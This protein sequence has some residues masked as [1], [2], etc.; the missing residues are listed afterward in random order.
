MDAEPF[1]PRMVDEAPASHERSF[2]MRKRSW[3]MALCLALVAGVMTALPATAQTEPGA[4]GGVVPAT[5][6]IADPDGDANGY[7]ALNPGSPG[8]VSFTGADILAVW[9]TNDETNLYVHI[10]TTSGARAESQ[11]F[12]T[13][14]GPA[15]KANCLQ[16]RM[17]TEGEAVEPFSSINLS[18]DC[19]TGTTPYGPLLEEVGPEETAILTGTFPLADVLKVSPAGL[20]AE[21]D[22]LIG[23]NARQVSPRVGIVDNTEVG[24]DYTISQ[25]PLAEPVPG[26]DDPPGK[27]KKKGCNKGKGKKKG[28]CGSNGRQMEYFFGGGL[29]TP[30]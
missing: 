13:S 11:T 4:T 10:Q 21:P 17:T 23:F 12:I 26:D 1:P 2:R 28:A 6:N 30:L 20:L 14:V 3:S 22:T 19:G 24:T 18:G 27:G 9:F 25:E 29:R 15:A 8:T 5:P 7:S 16:L